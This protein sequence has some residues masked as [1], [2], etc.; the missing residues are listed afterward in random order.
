MDGVVQVA[1]VDDAFDGAPVDGH[2]V[3]EGDVAV[4]GA[5][6]QP[7]GARGQVAEPVEHRCDQGPEV[8]AS[9]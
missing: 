5:G 7:R 9:R 3:A 4:E 8:G 6:R 1:E 2:D